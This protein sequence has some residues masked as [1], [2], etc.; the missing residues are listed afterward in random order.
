MRLQIANY[1]PDKRGGGW[2][3]V[4]NFTQHFTHDP[5]SDIFF[6]PGATMASHNE[7]DEAKR[8]GKKV[9]LR[10]D[11]AVRNSRNRGTGM[12]RMK[13]FAEKADLVV[14]QSKW[15][16]D[17]LYPFIKKDGVVILNGVDQEKFNKPEVPPAENTYLYARS[18]RDEG[19]QWIM[20]WYWFVNNPGTLEIV[21][22]FSNEN[23]EWKFDFY[24][25]EKIFYT[26]EHKDMSE[27]Y[28]RNKYFL[29]TYLNDACSNTLLEALSTGSKIIDVYGMLK[30]GGAP[31]IMR[32]NDG[33]E[34][35]HHRMNQQYAEELS[36]L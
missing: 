10:V 21:G 32:L 20:A 25:Q 6:I 4:R 22:R 19:K 35:S 29:Y 9:V 24:N 30:T 18:S 28:K 1:D 33:W 7:V 12:S 5:D 26:G 15:A 3:F 13:A 8:N 31:E 27:V 17:F 11:N 23:L 2:S 36:R 34:L 14:Y 16:R